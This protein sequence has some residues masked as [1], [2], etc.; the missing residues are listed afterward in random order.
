MASYTY[1]SPMDMVKWLDSPEERATLAIVDCRDEDRSEGWIINSIHMP[2][3]AYTPQAF[4]ALARSLSD[5]GMTRAV[6]H[7]ALSQ[8]RGPKGASR[9]VAAQ[10]ALGLTLPAVLV[11]SGG[12]ENFY[13]VYA[14]TR[15]DLMAFT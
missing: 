14:D 5:A 4:Q 9:F 7:C 3:T 8:V 11:L 13:N 6:F 15:R 10:Q 12:W 1:V 2:S